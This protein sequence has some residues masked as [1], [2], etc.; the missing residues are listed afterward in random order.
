[1]TDDA[2]LMFFSGHFDERIDVSTIFLEGTFGEDLCP[3]TTIENR[4]LVSQHVLKFYN[5]SFKF[6][7]A[8]PSIYGPDCFIPIPLFQ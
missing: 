7:Y 3:V 4:L 6:V 5:S 2:N 1:M 8:D